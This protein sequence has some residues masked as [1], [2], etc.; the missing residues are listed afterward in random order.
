MAAKKPVLG[1]RL[2]L[3][4]IKAINRKTSPRISHLNI[5]I[6]D[7]EFNALYI[8]RIAETA[9]PNA[10]IAYPEPV[11]LQPG[12]IGRKILNADGAWR[13]MMLFNMGLTRL[14][15]QANREP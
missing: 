12:E 3:L 9:Y 13:G 11:R 15:E 4:S 10:P 7:V 14:L 5:S 1:S 6:L 8:G 2:V